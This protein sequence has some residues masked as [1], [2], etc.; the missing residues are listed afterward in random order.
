MSTQK[1]SIF[2]GSVTVGGSWLGDTEI[3]FEL[4]PSRFVARWSC[5][6]CSY[7]CEA[8]DESEMEL[9]FSILLS[10]L[11]SHLGTHGQS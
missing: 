7:R 2:S 5:P 1:N 3:G 4:S 11:R 9:G 8:I 6:M 10:A